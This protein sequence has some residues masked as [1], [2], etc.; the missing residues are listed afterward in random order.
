MD[1]MST[2]PLRDLL[3][4]GSR[5][6]SPVVCVAALRGLATSGLRR[7]ARAPWKG[8]LCV[9]RMFMACMVAIPATAIWLFRVALSGLSVRRLLSNC[10]FQT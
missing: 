3:S 6:S 2:R 8:A 4:R 7:G 1:S 9:A 5:C 10:S